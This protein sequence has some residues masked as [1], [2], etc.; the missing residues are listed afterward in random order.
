MEDY[1]VESCQYGVMGQDGKGGTNPY[2][3]PKKKVT[4]AEFGTLLSRALR[5]DEFN[6]T[7]P[8][9]RENHLA[10]LNAV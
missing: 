5:G 7:G 3:N 10:E 2:F 8:D 6:T 4:R 1:I 9:F